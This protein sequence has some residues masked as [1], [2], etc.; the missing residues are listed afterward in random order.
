MYHAVFWPKP[1]TY[2]WGQL[3]KV[4]SN[5]SENNVN[6]VKMRFLHRKDPEKL[7]WTWPKIDDIDIVDADWLFEGPTITTTPAENN[8]SHAS[9]SQIQF[10]FEI[11]TEV[12]IKFNVFRKSKTF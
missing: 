3:Q 12:M 10:K 9:N 1:C 5:D 11:E 6:Q 8:S 2:Y 4:F 7:T